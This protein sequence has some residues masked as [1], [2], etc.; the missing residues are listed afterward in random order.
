MCGSVATA[1]LNS[2]EKAQRT[3]VALFD[4][5]AVIVLPPDRGRR[6]ETGIG[7]QLLWIAETANVI[8]LGIDQSGEELSD[9]G[10]GLQ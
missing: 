1:W 3:L 7:G 10:D 4:D 2:L 9:T 6:N 8:N 5:P